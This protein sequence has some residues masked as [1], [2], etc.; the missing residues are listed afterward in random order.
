M[1]CTAHV[2]FGGALD[3]ALAADQPS[4][5]QLSSSLV[6]DPAAGTNPGP[7]SSSACDLLCFITLWASLD[8]S[9]LTVLGLKGPSTL[10]AKAEYEPCRMQYPHC[11]S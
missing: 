11:C 3:R 9:G 1:S 5:V 7:M 10:L 6:Q 4:A 2:C 8:P